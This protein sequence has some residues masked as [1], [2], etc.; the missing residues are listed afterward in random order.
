MG[1]HASSLTKWVKKKKD[2]H[3]T[4]LTV[5]SAEGAQGIGPIY[6]SEE[7]NFTSDLPE[8]LQGP[9]LVYIYSSDY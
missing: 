1:A 4:S 8:S 3:S 2:S 9:E 7:K 5:C 6:Q